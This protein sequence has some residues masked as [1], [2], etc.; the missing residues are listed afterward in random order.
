MA[1]CEDVALA[2]L[3]IGELP[4]AGKVSLETPAVP[5]SLDLPDDER[6]ARNS[7]EE[8][9]KARRSVPR[10]LSSGAPDLGQVTGL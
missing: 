5:V 2:P 1:P 9:S 4:L 6:N 3:L 8:G 10:T 7:S